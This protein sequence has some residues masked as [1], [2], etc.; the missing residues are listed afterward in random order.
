M[1]GLMP[2]NGDGR[3]LLQRRRYL[4][5]Y[6][7][8]RDSHVENERLTKTNEREAELIKTKEISARH[9]SFTGSA[10]GQPS[11]GRVYRPGDA[12][13]M[14]ISGWHRRP[15]QGSGAGVDKDQPVVTRRPGRESHRSPPNASRVLPL[16][17]E[18]HGAGAMIGQLS[19]ERVLGVV[20]GR[21]VRY[22]R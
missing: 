11:P 6:F 2:F 13:A 4:K 21:T 14:R 15:R 8:L 3:S 5:N 7:A 12:R 16:T 1:T 10:N 19:N 17:D 18:R 22:A 9:C 20:T